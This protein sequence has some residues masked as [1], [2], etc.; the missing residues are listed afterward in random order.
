[1]KSESLNEAITALRS[2]QPDLLW[3]ILYDPTR[4]TLERLAALS[5]ALSCASAD[6]KADLIFPLLQDSDL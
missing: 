4:S 6:S 1:M 3:G 5:V 2:M